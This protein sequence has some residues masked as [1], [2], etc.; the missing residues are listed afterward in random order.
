[1]IVCLTISY[2]LLCYT[3]TLQLM[4]FFKI[5]FAEK[6]KWLCL[7]PQPPLLTTILRL[8][9]ESFSSTAFRSGRRAPLTRTSRASS[10]EGEQSRLYF[11]PLL[12]RELPL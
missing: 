6:L 11:S 1:M 9:A 3:D 4:Y 8:R 10:G 7:T 2:W 12:K 5:E